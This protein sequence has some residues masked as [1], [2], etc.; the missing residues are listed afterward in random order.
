MENIL[1]IYL[2]INPFLERERERY[3]KTHTTLSDHFLGFLIT[4]NCQDYGC[5]LY[6]C[7]KFNVNLSFSVTDT[8]LIVHFYRRAAAL[9]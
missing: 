7:I 9:R 2:Y 3:V 8:F 4:K 5:L 6:R 1:F